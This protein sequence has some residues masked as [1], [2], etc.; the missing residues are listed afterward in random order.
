M[1]F[2]AL[3][4]PLLEGPSVR[5]SRYAL[6]EPILALVQPSRPLGRVAPASA[7]RHHVHQKVMLGDAGPGVDQGKVPHDLVVQ[8]L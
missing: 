6:Q 1:S 8:L 7:V 5:P 4:D 2:D 3:E